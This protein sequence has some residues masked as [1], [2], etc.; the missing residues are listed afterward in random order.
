MALRTRNL[1]AA[2]AELCARG[3]E[4]LTEPRSLDPESGIVAVVCCRDPDG[5]LVEFIEYEPGVLGS[6][7]DNLP[8]RES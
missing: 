5:L 4:F 2:Y 6:K 3:I 1:R 7:I 8:R